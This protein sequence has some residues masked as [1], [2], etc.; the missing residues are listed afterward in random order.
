MFNS[1]NNKMKISIKEINFEKEMTFSQI[2]S[3]KNVEHW[4]EILTYNHS[5]VRYHIFVSNLGNVFGWKDGNK[6]EITYKNGRR[7]FGKYPIFNL[8]AKYLC[9]AKTGHEYNVHHLNGNKLDDRACNL[10]Q[11]TI[12]Q[13]MKIERALNNPMNNPDSKAK[14]IA[15]MKKTMSNPEVRALISKRTKEG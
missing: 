2:L 4:V 9:D 15:T 12:S 10:V 3:T 8:V 11:L 6:I 5:V 14:M 13:H 7:F 1:N